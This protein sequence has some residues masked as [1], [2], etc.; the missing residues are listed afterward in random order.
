LGKT[1]ELRARQ[2]PV[3][4]RERSAAIRG[5]LASDAG[6]QWSFSYFTCSSRQR[7]FRVLGELPVC[8][9]EAYFKGLPRGVRRFATSVKLPPPFRIRPRKLLFLNNN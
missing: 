1:I 4:D 5:L 3:T 6:D 8:A 2:S 9:G 7:F